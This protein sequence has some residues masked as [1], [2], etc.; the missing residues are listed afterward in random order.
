LVDATTLPIENLQLWRESKGSLDDAEIS[1][2]FE[3]LQFVAG[4]GGTPRWL[5]VQ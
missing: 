2:A 4:E 1:D 5:V 3:Q